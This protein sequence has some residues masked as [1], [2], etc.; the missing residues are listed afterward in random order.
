MA[1]RRLTFEAARLALR[2][3]IR[4]RTLPCRHCGSAR[5][6]YDARA[7]GAYLRKE[8]RVRNVGLR[9]IAKP[10]GVSPS[11]VS[12]LELGRREW[13]RELV[14]R[15]AEALFAIRP[16]PEPVAARGR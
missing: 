5:K 7:V 10:L 11:Y 9:E 12:D 3:S 2:A 13:S 16:S 15:F 6:E 14:R 8:R 1:E 4:T